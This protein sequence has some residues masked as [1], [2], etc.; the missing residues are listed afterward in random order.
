MAKKLLLSLLIC[1]NLNLQALISTKSFFFYQCSDNLGCNNE[2][3]LII[4]LMLSL[5][6]N[7]MLIVWLFANR[8][9]SKSY[10]TS[11]I[12]LSFFSIRVLLSL[13]GYYSISGPKREQLYF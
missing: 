12:I 3:Y 9:F 4:P 6:A 1:L 8:N 5:I 2:L 11:A 10:R 7:I 13:I